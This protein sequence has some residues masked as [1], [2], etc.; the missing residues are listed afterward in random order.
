MHFKTCKKREKWFFFFP[1]L[2]YWS[3]NTGSHEATNKAFSCEL[4]PTYH[5]AFY[6]EKVLTNLSNLTLTHSV[7]QQLKDFFSLWQ[8]VYWRDDWSYDDRVTV[9]SRYSQHL[10][11]Q[12]QKWL[13]NDHNAARAFTAALLVL[14]HISL[15]W[16]VL[17]TVMDY[18]VSPDTFYFSNRFVLYDRK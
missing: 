2:H 18:Q 9:L 12:Q 16:M 3:L 5:L 17:P 7:S 1:L 13:Q 10:L 8:V 14:V 15:L 4:F 6:F 11:P